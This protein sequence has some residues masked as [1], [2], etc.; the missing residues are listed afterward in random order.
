M[1]VVST[2]GFVAQMILFSKISD[3]KFGGTH[4]TLLNTISNLGF[5]MLSSAAMM[6][7]DRF[8]E[9]NCS[10]SYVF[11]GSSH[12]SCNDMETAKMCKDASGQCE[13]SKDGF[14]PVSLGFCTLG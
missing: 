6:S 10:V 13:V 5:K 8:S 1:T 4:M 3:P 7:V 2:A 12:T 9:R 11:E 14:F